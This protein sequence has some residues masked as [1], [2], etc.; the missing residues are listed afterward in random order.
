MRSQAALAF[1]GRGIQFASQLVMVLV[2]PKVLAPGLYAELYL[3]LPLATLGVSLV[4]GWLTGAINRHVHELLEPKN[5]HI[6]QTVFAYHG[7]VSLSLVAAFTVISVFT[8]SNYRLVLL[9]VMSMGLKES[10]VGALNMSGNY[11]GFILANSGFAL[12]LLVFIGLCSFSAA[13][14]LA[15]YLIIY[16]TVDTILALFAWHLVGV[17]TFKPLP[18]FDTVVAA[19][20]LRYGLPLVARGLPLWVM[21]VSDRYLL[22]AWGAK[23]SLAAYILSYQLAGSAIAIPL[24]F[25]MAAVFP[26]ILRIDRESGEAAALSYTHRIL[27]YYLRYMVVV[28]IGAC[29]LVLSITYYL[30]PEYKFMPAV[31]VIIVLAHVI[32]GLTHFYNKEFELN[33]RTMV[34]TKAVSVGAGVNLGLNVVL[35]P[36]Y[37]ALGAALSTLAAYAM[38]VILLYMARRYRHKST[39][40]ERTDNK[41]YE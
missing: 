7:F 37:G 22:A 9:L 32:Q 11:K 34:I 30:Y 4:F 13:D 5:S 33:G 16:S 10:I 25:V 17:A 14:D 35:I 15:S 24:S 3:L 19:R 2:L 40:S 36:F 39:N 38:T 18:Q 23:D 31:I 6:R 12:S 26:R 28:I 41:G 29:G 8:S 21:S 27:G 20:Y 1:L